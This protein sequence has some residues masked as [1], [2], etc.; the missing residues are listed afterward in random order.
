MTSALVLP[1]PFLPTHVYAP[2]ADALGRRGWGVAVSSPPAAPRDAA[3]VLD[4][5]GA[6]AARASP[7]VVVAHSNAG[8]YAAAVAP[9]GAVVLYADAALP[10]DSGDA[11]LAPATLLD[12]LAAMADDDAFLPPW[13]R[14]WDEEDIA[15]VVP[16]PVLLERIRADEPRVP[17]SYARSRLGA[18]EGWRGRRSG[19]LAFGGTYAEE[20]GRARSWGWPVHVL[21]GALHLHLLLEP[22]EVADEVVALAAACAAS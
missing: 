12:A 10:P 13:T 22:G 19:Y 11:T 20:V 1:S 6:D 16:D 5:F 4:A 8:R 7:D 21:A 3:A 15:P 14:W 18:P 2:L 9:P 17:L